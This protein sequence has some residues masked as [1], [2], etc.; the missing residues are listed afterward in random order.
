MAFINP[1][2]VDA[3]VDDQQVREEKLARVLYLILSDIWPW[4]QTPRLRRSVKRASRCGRVGHSEAI[5]VAVS[6]KSWGQGLK[7]RRF[8]RS[9]PT[10][11]RH[12][13]SGFGR[14]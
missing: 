12:G 5:H 10:N 7:I 3:E 6:D 8:G 11:P 4:H 2:G 14:R 9:V 13:M 1:L